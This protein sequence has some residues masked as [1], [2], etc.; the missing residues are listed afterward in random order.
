MGY[1]FSKYVN[2]YNDQYEEL[3]VN[4]LSNME[5]VLADFE[6]KIKYHHLQH[7]KLNDDSSIYKLVLVNE[8]DR[9]VDAIA[10]FEFDDAFSLVGLVV[11]TR[12][13]RDSKQNEFVY[14][15]GYCVKE[16][17]RGNGVADRL[18]AESILGLKSFW[19][20]SGPN[21]DIGPDNSFKYTLESV[22]AQKNEPS[23]RL[24]KKLLHSG[25]D[26][27]VAKEYRSQEISNVYRMSI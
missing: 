11:C 26:V 8:S 19:G 20:S 22:V 21:L 9:F 16:K 18:V 10:F 2:F 27:V 25:G 7:E 17:Y 23:N 14:S 15:V 1:S 4:D 3:F 13:A 12:N 6:E 5:K 24:A